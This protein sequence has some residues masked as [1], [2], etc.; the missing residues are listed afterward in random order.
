VD[1]FIAQL[2][3]L[4]FGGQETTR[5]LVSTVIWLCI[6]HI[7][8]LDFLRNGKISVSGCVEE[9]LRY[10]SPVQF[11]ARVCAEDIELN[12]V[13]MAAGQPVLLM[14]GSANRDETAFSSPDEFLPTRVSKEP[15][16]AFGLGGHK[17]IGS[18]LALLQAEVALAVLLRRFASIRLITD[19]PEW[20]PNIGVRGLKSLLLE[21][22]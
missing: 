18:Q 2:I 3:L 1:S 20:T 10:E 21:V 11:I 17:C 4:V 6:R 19:K 15:L 16:L 8:Q 14:L 5:Q 12:G 9:A 13:R 7:D 22:Q